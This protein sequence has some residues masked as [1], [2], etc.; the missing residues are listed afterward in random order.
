MDSA[1]AAPDIY[2]TKGIEYLLVLG[3]LLLLLF[4]WRLLH[5]PAPD[6]RKGGLLR[7]ALS[8]IGS[9]LYVLFFPIIGIGMVA[10]MVLRRLLPGPR[11][12]IE[13]LGAVMQDGG[14]PLEK[15]GGGE[16]EDAQAHA[17]P[18]RSPADKEVT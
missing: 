6:G 9:L 14:E 16:A 7:S 11:P 8:V 12:Q 5:E 3:F 1:A 13:A 2:A 17:A 15:A 4:F 18:A 10:W